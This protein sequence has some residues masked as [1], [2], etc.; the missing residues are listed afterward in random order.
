MTQSKQ[1]KYLNMRVIILVDNVCL[2]SQHTI[3]VQNKRS[4]IRIVLKRMTHL[5]FIL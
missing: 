1:R 3:V 5:S 4:K 2:F